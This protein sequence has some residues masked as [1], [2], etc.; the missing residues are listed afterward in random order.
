MKIAV[1]GPG[2]LGTLFA[3]SL[4]STGTNEVCLLDHNPERAARID[5]NI[6]LDI[7]GKKIALNIPVF[8]DANKIGKPD[9]VLLC[10]KSMNVE[11]ALN[12]AAPLFDTNTLL[13][14]F[15]NGIGHI[16]IIANSPI[17]FDFAF[18]VTSQGATLIAPG[19]VRHGGAGVTKI[20]FP[21]KKDRLLQQKLDKTASILTACGF[22]TSVES[23]ILDHIWG[24]LLV[25]VGINALTVIYDC[26]NGELLNI[27]EARDTLIAAVEEG[28]KVASA[29][30]ISFDHDPVELTLGVCQTT[31]TNIS[32][33][34][35]DARNHKRT[36]IDA[37]NGALVQ[38]AEIFSIDT[39]VNQ[40]LVDQ[41]KQCEKRYLS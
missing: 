14:P 13:I 36:E 2:A 12:H 37:I 31:A 17:S 21:D 5:G 22:Q 11:Q 1:V 24:K 3:A 29:L 4:A 15:Q 32:S 8:A 7:E 33:M 38:K 41:V 26:P 6:I 28:K 18:G 40:N 19:H 9:L 39:P 16:D 35:Q 10:V 20:G 23:N 25:N 27:R 34:L 30:G